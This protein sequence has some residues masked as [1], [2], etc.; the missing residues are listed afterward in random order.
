MFSNLND[1]ITVGFCGL[2]SFLISS[3]LVFDLQAELHL[4]MNTEQ[5]LKHP[6]GGL[7][8]GVKVCK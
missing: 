6:S 4:L 1:S 3:A 5:W 7:E 8:V 2:V